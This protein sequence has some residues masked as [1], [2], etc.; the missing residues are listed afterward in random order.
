MSYILHINTALD[1]ASVSLAVN[2]H[3]I[4]ERL[5]DSQKE[6]ASFL[7]VAI[8]EITSIAGIKLK[9]LSAVAVI[10]GPGS[11][12]GLRVGMSGAKGIC[13]ALSI[14]LITVNTLEW[15]A[16]ACKEEADLFCPMIDARRMEVFTAMYNRE[17][18]E[19]APPTA[20]IL[21]PDSF[22]PDLQAKKIVFFGNGAKKFSAL[23]NHP[24]ASFKPVFP[25]TR[26]LAEIAWNLYQE[27]TFADLT[28]AEPLY[29][30]EFYTPV[31]PS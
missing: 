4:A 23:I 7:Q 29:V 21:E 24:N 30:K 10:H 19:V 1:N 8:A 16:A 12:T 27:R 18:I 28:Y 14:P 2:D 26:E 25:G 9:N 15:M 5:S 20:M 31:K 3:V 17:K 13:F 6:H 11:Y 22:Q